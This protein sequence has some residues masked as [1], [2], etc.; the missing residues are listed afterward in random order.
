MDKTIAKIYDKISPILD[1]LTHRVNLLKNFYLAVGS[2]LILLIIA[3]PELVRGPIGSFDEELAEVILI[4][5]LFLFCFLVYYLY[6]LEVKKNREQLNAAL[7][8]IGSINI[9]VSQIKSIFSDIKK[10]PENKDD[11][12]H[13]LKLLANKVL[14]AVNVEWVLFRIIQTDSLKTLVELDETRGGS[15]EARRYNFSNRILC[16]GKNAQGCSVF[17]S[18]QNNSNVRAFCVLPGNAVDENQKI[19]IQAIADN[20]GMLYLIFASI[21]SKNGHAQK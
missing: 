18:T 17:E 11:F 14:G 15:E 16:A 12:R 20:L 21:Y 4:T 7:I 19:L 9:Q 5:L 13:I 8:H 10:Y 1:F 2:V 3:T 6:H